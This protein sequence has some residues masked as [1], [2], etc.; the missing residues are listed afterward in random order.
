MPSVHGKILFNKIFLPVRRRLPAP[1]FI[2]AFMMF[3]MPLI[4]SCAPHHISPEKKL[5]VK[6]YSSG[7]HMTPA[8]SL[9]LPANP[10]FME[11]EKEKFL[12]IASLTPSKTGKQGYA[13]SDIIFSRTKMVNVSADQIALPDFIHY[14]FSDIFS[15][16]YVVD[17]NIEK[18]RKSVSLNLNRK[19]SEYELFQLVETILRQYKIAIYLKKGIYYIWKDSGDKKIALGIGD[20]VE[21]I[22]ETSGQIQQIIPVKHADVQNLS[23]FLP[24]LPGLRVL[25]GLRENVLLVKGT[26]EQVEQVLSFVTMLDRPAMRGRF[27][28][29]MKVIYW[30]PLDLVKKL[31]DILTEEGIPVTERT[32]RRG[33]YMTTIERW[34]IIIIFAAQKKWLKRIRY[35]AKILDVPSGRKKEYF[36]YFPQNSRA[37]ELG[38]SLQNIMGLSAQEKSGSKHLT[39][40]GEIMKNSQSGKGEKEKSAGK[41]K[42]VNE[43]S[44][45]GTDVRLTVDESRNALI[46]HTTP[47]K[48]KTIR[49]LLEQLDI[50]PV[51]VL[52]EAAVAEVTLTG[53]LQYGLEWFIK[54]NSGTQT[55]TLS[56]LGGLGIGKGGLDY[57]MITDSE[58]FKLVINALAKKDRVKILFSPHLTVRDG[59]SATITV[60]TEV[61]VITSEAT[62]PDIQEEGT[63]GIIRSVQ[64]RST[65]VTLAVTPSV[66]AAGVVT[67]EINQQVSEAQA[68]TTSDIDSP[69]IMNRTVTTEVVAADGQTVLLGGLIKENNS[70]TVTKVPLLGDIPLLGYLFKTTSKGSDRTELVVMITPHIVRNT[71]QI[72][73]MKDTLFKGFQHLGMIE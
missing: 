5:N 42:I 30:S 12:S 50:M 34:G 16:N 66:Q 27:I 36:L 17:T 28:G 44:S 71:Q 53:S 69:I 45:I 51:Q 46:F 55:G 65:G 39:R 62:T 48:Y 8:G 40:A 64:Y 22:P 10:S 59:K 68:N 72:D 6:I 26:R 23:E 56:T 52:L 37:S 35:W 61:P 18:S 4:F 20:S 31:T 49:S 14:I 9:P 21:D 19:I 29:M 33:V 15:A 60:G 41:E 58:K 43:I 1:D 32:G 25:P 38:E 7:K 67:L 47:D 70:R 57:S 11:E 2:V 24:G 73:E 3:F 63:S 13:D 54:N